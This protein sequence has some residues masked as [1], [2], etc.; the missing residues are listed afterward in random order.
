MKVMEIINEFETM[1]EK[2]LNDATDFEIE[3][4]VNAP[5]EI[6]AMATVNIRVAK[7]IHRGFELLSYEE[8][9]SLLV[10]GSN[11]SQAFMMQG[12]MM[13][14][15]KF[16]IKAQFIQ[17]L[18]EE[19]GFK[20]KEGIKMVKILKAVTEDEFEEIFQQFLALNKDDLMSIQGLGIQK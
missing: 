10:L 11:F 15:S 13:Q 18:Y 2:I 19:L 8:I 1:S 20:N 3:E 5:M 14:N 7:A 9:E 16:I 17:G 4:F 6:K 12:M